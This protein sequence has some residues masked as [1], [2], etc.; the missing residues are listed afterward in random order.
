MGQED[1]RILDRG[2][3]NIG[4]EEGRILDKKIKK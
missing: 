2:K 3:Q 1:G 4:N